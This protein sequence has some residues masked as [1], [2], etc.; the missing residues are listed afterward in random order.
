MIKSSVV[1][2][3]MEPALKIE[4]EHVLQELG[5]TPTQAVNMLYKY[6]VR[7]HE[8]PFELKI[9]NK[10]TRKAFEETDKGVGL[11][12]VSNIDELFKKLKD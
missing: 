8:W 7:E 9:P 2:A 5:I 1:R 4:A 10:E 6:V 12:K 11:A 3:R